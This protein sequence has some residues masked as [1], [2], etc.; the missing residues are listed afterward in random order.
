MPSKQTERVI[1]MDI[2]RIARAE[3]V[4]MKPYVSARNSA[5]ADGILLNANEAPFPHVQDPRWQ[6]LAL[7]RYPSP[8]PAQLK[9]RMAELYGV[10]ESNVLVTRGSDEGIDLLTRVFCRAGRDAIVECTPC[11]GMYRISA[12]IQAAT[13]IEIPRLEDRGWQIDYE[14]LE[15]TIKSNADV[16]LVFLTTP[17]N[18]S[19]DLIERDAL[20]QVLAACEDKALVVL[21]E[22]Y[23]EFCFARSASELI[24]EWPQLVVLRTLSKAWAAAGIRCGTVIADPNVI[25]LLQRVIAPYPLASTAIDAALQATSGEAVARQQDFIATVRQGR[26]DMYQF[27]SACDWVDHVWESEANFILLRV[28]D[29]PGLVAFCANAGIRIRDFSTQPQL[30]GCVRLTIGS[31]QELAAL[32]TVLQA[33]GEGQ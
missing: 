32:K 7:N 6:Q 29:A 21:D 25:S 22:A 18:P 16:K 4:A 31:D 15:A 26:A 19:G 20:E 5:S 3:I 17:N 10:D 30:Q 1:V 2:N 27:L 8:Q 9:A 33:F 28:S 24:S 11:F 13:V 12:T 23:I 14:K